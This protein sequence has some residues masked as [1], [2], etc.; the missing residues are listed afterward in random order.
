MNIIENTKENIKHI[1][2][3]NGCNVIVYENYIS[4]KKQLNLFNLCKNKPFEFDKPLGG[5]LG[6]K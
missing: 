3:Y 4:Y 6:K 2:D 1:I 5:Y